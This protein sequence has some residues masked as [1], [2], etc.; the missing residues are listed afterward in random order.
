MSKLTKKKIIFL[1]TLFCLF[2]IVFLI[3]TYILF[4]I[5][6]VL[7]FDFGEINIG[8]CDNKTVLTKL[9]EEIDKF[10]YKLITVDGNEYTVKL[11]DVIDP[12]DINK[13]ENKVNGLKKKFWANKYNLSIE[14]LFVYNDDKIN[15]VLNEIK[16]NMGEDIESVDA[17]IVYDKNIKAFK[18]EEEKYGNIFKSDACNILKNELTSLSKD[19]NLVEIGCYI[20]PNVFSDDEVLHENLLKYNEYQG[21]NIVY[22]FGE[23]KEELNLDI[24]QSWLIPNLDENNKLNDEEPFTIKEDLVKEY[25]KGLSSKYNTLGK[26]RTFK[27]STDE[28]VEILKG[29]YG[30]WL[31]ENKMIEDIKNLL[32]NKECIEKEA[33]F[34]QKAECF[35]DTDFTNSY[36]EVSIEKQHLWM[37]VNGNLVIDCPVVTGC[38]SK[39]HSTPKGIY[40]LTYKTKNAVL[41]GPGYASPVSYWMPFNGGVGLHDA[42][43]RGSFGGAIYKTNGSHGCVNMPLK[44]AKVVYENLTSTMPIIVW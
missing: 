16:Q 9:E 1:S 17:C 44:A 41:R 4:P 28:T 15:A 22:I 13:L 33:I 31:N 26:S 12:I 40:S 39:G 36:V 14:D 24:Y 42:T 7:L 2:L 35:G 5:N 34:K 43:W 10:E 32:L 21:K 23:N 38:V 3:F 29:D 18:I 25:V 27:T 6:S 37:Y 19:I 11:N 8:F 30:W 20:P